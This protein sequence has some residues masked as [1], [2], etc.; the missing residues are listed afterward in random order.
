MPRRNPLHDDDPTLDADL[1]WALN[2]IKTEGDKLARLGETT[3][4]SVFFRDYLPKLRARTVG[5][6]QTQR[7]RHSV[8]REISRRTDRAI[9]LMIEAAQE[10]GYLNHHGWTGLGRLKLTDLIGTPDDRHMRVFASWSDEKFERILDVAREARALSRAGLLRVDAGEPASLKRKIQRYTIDD[11]TTQRRIY[12][13]AVMTMDGVA[14]AVANLGDIHPKITQGERD[15]WLEQL[16]RYR[17][18]LSHAMNKLR[19]QPKPQ[20]PPPSSTSP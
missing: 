19:T 1:E 13:G 12:Q 2:W 16:T 17:A 5:D 14:T 8:M 3:E 4:L 20:S 10:R 15:E 7:N 9:G 6:H 11:A 18:K